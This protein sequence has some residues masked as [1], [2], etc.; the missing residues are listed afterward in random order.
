MENKK[1]KWTRKDSPNIPSLESFNDAYIVWKE[2]DSIKLQ[3]R[4]LQKIDLEK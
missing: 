2:N 4:M 3:T 1:A